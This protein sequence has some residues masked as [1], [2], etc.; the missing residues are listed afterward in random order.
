MIGLHRYGE[1]ATAHWLVD[2][3]APHGASSMPAA[4][5]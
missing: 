3:W 2:Y 4:G 5:G 1:G